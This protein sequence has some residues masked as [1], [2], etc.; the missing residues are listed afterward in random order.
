[1]LDTRYWIKDAKYRIFVTEWALYY[2][3]VACNV[4]S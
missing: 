3:A 4:Q 1:M 2:L